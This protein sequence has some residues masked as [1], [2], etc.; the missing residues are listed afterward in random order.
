MSYIRLRCRRRRRCRLH[1]DGYIV[2]S[3]D[4][5]LARA[6]VHCVPSSTTS[7]ECF[8]FLAALSANSKYQPGIAAVAAVAGTMCARMLINAS[9]YRP[10][11]AFQ[12]VSD[13]VK[14]VVDTPL[15]LT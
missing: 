12:T 4:A 11:S 8:S 5:I 7:A 9:A 14:L 15:T 3:E 1:S 10:L 2:E 6:L 13:I